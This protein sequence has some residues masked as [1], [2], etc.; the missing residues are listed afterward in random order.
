MLYPVVEQF[1]SIQGEGYWTGRPAVFV[2]LAGCNRRCIFCDTDYKEKYRLS[3][4]VI[5][6]NAERL[7][8]Q[9]SAGK[10]VVFTG[11]EPALTLDA[12]LPKIFKEMG[13]YVSVETNGDYIR[14]SIPYV[15][16][17]TVSPKAA[18]AEYENGLAANEIKLLYDI[19]ID[20]AGFLRPG[21]Y[22]EHM[23]LQPVDEEYMP[24]YEYCLEH[25]EWRI[26]LQTHKILGVR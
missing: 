25:P 11:G 22:F 15:D 3:E 19:D 23:F 26:S 1:Y 10:M 14:N 17:I 6:K 8:P 12:N 4:I 24:A 20:P 16:W 21:F 9:G 7:W 18:A 5:C 2:R 13:W